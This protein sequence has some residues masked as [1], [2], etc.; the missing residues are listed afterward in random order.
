MEIIVL[1]G[2]TTMYG[3]YHDPFTNASESLVRML[4]IAALLLSFICHYLNL[5]T[6]RYSHALIAF[7]TYL[8]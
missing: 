5:W 7:S 2:T 3:N 4:R 8:K 1:T 6:S